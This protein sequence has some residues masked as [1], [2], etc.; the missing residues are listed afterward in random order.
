MKHITFALIFAGIVFTAHPAGAATQPK[1]HELTV[2]ISKDMPDY[3]L[4]IAEPSSILRRIGIEVHWHSMPACPA[5][6]MHVRVLKTA[7]AGLPPTAL[8]CAHPL[9]GRDAEVY[10]DRIEAA[11]VQARV[12]TLT[13][14]VIAHEIIHLLE[15]EATR[16]ADEGIMRTRWTGVDVQVMAWGWKLTADDIKLIRAGMRER[17]ARI[18]AE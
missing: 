4:M 3:N 1:F 9:E 18:D 17:Q 16:H 12:A 5:D 6:A 13:G 2:C 8:G 14:Y 11:V 15:G 10:M 7:P